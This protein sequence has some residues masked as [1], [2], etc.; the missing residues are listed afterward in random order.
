LPVADR[1]DHA[2]RLA[3]LVLGQVHRLGAVEGGQVDGLRALLRQV[4]D[5]LA[6]VAQQVDRPGVGLTD[7]EDAVPERVHRA[8]G[9]RRAVIT[10][11]PASNSSTSIIRAAHFTTGAPSRYMNSRPSR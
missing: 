7:L 8:I 9:V 11:R 5:R 6:A 1:R 4:A 2:H 10:W 3:A